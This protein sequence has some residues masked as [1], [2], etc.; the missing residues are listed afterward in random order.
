MY[1][2]LP[3]DRCTPAS[4]LEASRRGPF[5]CFT[6]RKPEKTVELYQ[7]L[8][9]ENIIVSLREGKIRVSPHLFNCE[10]DMDR[11]VSVVRDWQN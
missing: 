4:P 8:R 10:Q 3:E 9:R 11:L 7:K 5:G 1:R 2:H 6:A